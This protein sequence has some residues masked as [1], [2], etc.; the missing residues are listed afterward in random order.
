[1]SVLVEDAK[2]RTANEDEEVEKKST[3]KLS[4]EQYVQID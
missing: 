4:E 1:M 2:N 3:G